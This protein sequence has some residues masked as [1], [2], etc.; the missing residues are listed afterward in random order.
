MLGRPC[1]TIDVRRLGGT[2]HMATSA[3]EA[4]RVRLRLTC[5]SPPAAP[6]D[7]LAAFG[8]QDKNEALQPGQSQADG[9]VSYEC[10]PAVK[11]RA[12]TGEP[13]FAGPYVHGAAGARSLDLSLRDA[14]AGT[15]TNR[16]KI[17]LAGITWAL[18]DAADSSPGGVLA[19]S[20]SGSGSGTVAL[21]GSGWALEQIPGGGG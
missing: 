3:P 18:L 13:D 14:A 10:D 7:R 8:L 19:G 12:A 16:L 1:Y 6:A 15:W 5:M 20:I 17:P 9:S 2:I 11:P 21:L 4:R